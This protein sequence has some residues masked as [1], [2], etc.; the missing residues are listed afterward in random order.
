MYRFNLDGLPKELLPL[1]LLCM[2]GSTVKTS[3]K[4][5]GIIRTSESRG[6]VFFLG[7]LFAM[8][9][10]DEKSSGAARFFPRGPFS[11]LRLFSGDKAQHSE[12]FPGAFGA[13]KDWSRLR[14][15]IFLRFSLFLGHAPAARAVHLR[16]PCDFCMQIHFWDRVF[17]FSEDF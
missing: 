6:R 4:T 2:V 8:R 11:N 5:R 9:K 1:D 14:R 7:V 10:F 3:K 12:K 13:E 15:V 16:F 17:F